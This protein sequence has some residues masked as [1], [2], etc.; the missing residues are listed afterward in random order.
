VE[1][2]CGS[3]AL[4][5]DAMRLMDA[6]VVAMMVKELPPFF[7]VGRACVEGR[8]ALSEGGVQWRLR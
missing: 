3:G 8:V 1:H 4:D 5:E 2:V 7:V 6:K